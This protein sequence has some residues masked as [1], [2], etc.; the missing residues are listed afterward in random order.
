[1]HKDSLSREESL[2]IEHTS[3]SLR[4]PHILHCLTESIAVVIELDKFLAPSLFSPNKNM[5]RRFAVLGPT[6]GNI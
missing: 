3:K 1:M 2:Q 5:A 4:T 6:P